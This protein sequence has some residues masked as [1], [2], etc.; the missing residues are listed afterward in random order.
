MQWSF[1]HNITL[2]CGLG[3][4]YLVVP[5]S[6]W[7][8]AVAS[9]EAAQ[10]A[11]QLYQEGLQLFQQE[12][13][14]EAGK[15][16]RKGVL[17]LI[18]HKEAG[19][20]R[21]KLLNNISVVG[22]IVGRQEQ[23][24][25]ALVA[26]QREVYCRGQEPKG[27]AT[28]TVTVTEELL[29][30]DVY[31]NAA[32]LF[33]ELGDPEQALQSLGLALEAAQEQ[34][35]TA[36]RK[37]GLL[38]LYSA[39]AHVQMGK[40]EDALRDIRHACELLKESLNPVGIASLTLFEG[41]LLREMGDL[42][43]A[44]V[45]YQ[46]ALGQL[47]AL[48]ET[49]SRA[50]DPVTALNQE[51]ALAAA[52]AGANEQ[53]FEYA[54]AAKGRALA[55]QLVS[56]MAGL[57]STKFTQTLLVDVRQNIQS[58]VN[59]VQAG[60][61]SGVSAEGVAVLPVG[62]PGISAAKENDKSQ[63]TD[64]LRDIVVD[65][66]HRDPELAVN[67]AFPKFL[68]SDLAQVLGPDEAVVDYL[69]LEGEALANV[70]TQSGVSSVVLPA[71]GAVIDAIAQEFRAARE[72]LYDF[73]RKAGGRAPA[74]VIAGLRHRRAIAET[75]L[76]RIYQLAWEPVQQALGA[77]TRI[78]IVPDGALAA[79]PFQILKDGQGKFLID[80]YEFVY[81]PTVYDFVLARKKEAPEQGGP[82]IV[83]RNDFSQDRAE[84]L[85]AGDLPGT[86]EE[87]RLIAE[88]YQ[89][90]HPRLL[91]EDQ[92]TEAAL[93]H[94]M[95]NCSVLHLATHARFLPEDPWGS[96]ILLR[97]GGG[98]DGLLTA[99]EIYNATINSKL[100]VLSACQTAV[101]A[102]REALGGPLPAADLA[103]LSRSF[104]H[105]GCP[106]IL[107]TLWSVLDQPTQQIMVAT[108]AG[109][110]KG[111]A[112]VAALR[113]AQLEYM[114]QQAQMQ[115]A[116]NH[117]TEGENVPLQVRY[118]EPEPVEPVAP[119]TLPAAE[120]DWVAWGAFIVMGR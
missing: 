46:A 38:S 18:D 51:G 119:V 70:A 14:D 15:Q 83:A 20:L 91:S 81:A 36:D 29:G 34:N 86:L 117:K 78:V 9:P 53:A 16:W 99:G 30:F 44:A 24:A 76:E 62:V 11:E 96:Y 48:P 27:P 82:V 41:R 72:E 90:Q 77:R 94:N 95:Q 118:L 37:I 5:T 67:C 2:A 100:V 8:Q 105:A 104:V 22:A 60:N 47:P 25:R 55:G 39:R 120:W 68:F 40:T 54:T 73:V 42:T 89:N 58:L 28:V 110:A 50:Q 71:S 10:Q 84:G 92:A 111:L 109:I 79:V 98:E 3:L 49:M 61:Q 106:N 87:A 66:A 26:A 114:R 103:S 113:Q 6:G 13:F 32:S 7:T 102:G 12:Q 1:R 31:L 17:L 35:I 116:G 88:V 59:Q 57:S 74:E 4:A 112:P 93:K 52:Q 43:G 33:L 19:A 69:L 63:A 23:A 65:L 115:P 80:K 75:K 108:H 107:A 21:Q 45:L 85:P 56:G 64:R 101:R 97:P